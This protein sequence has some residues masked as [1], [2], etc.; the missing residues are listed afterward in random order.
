M[1][2]NVVSRFE[3]LILLSHVVA[4]SLEEDS[5]RGMWYPSERNQAVEES[6]VVEDLGNGTY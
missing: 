5:G 1:G 4:A 3:I 2:R 6:A